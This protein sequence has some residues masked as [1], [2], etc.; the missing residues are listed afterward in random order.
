MDSVT[1]EGA[2]HSG[3]ILLAVGAFLSI[4]ITQIVTTRLNSS[5]I[6]AL[7]KQVKRQNG[8]QRKMEVRCAALHGVEAVLDDDDDE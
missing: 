3:E 4:I 5:K 8:R 2:A 1:L 6:E 7:T